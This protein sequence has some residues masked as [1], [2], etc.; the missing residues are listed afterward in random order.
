MSAAVSANENTVQRSQRKQPR[1]RKQCYRCGRNH[2]PEDCW[3]KSTECRRCMK[4]GHI[5]RMCRSEEPKAEN[6]KRGQYGK[7]NYQR[8]S[9][10]KESQATSNTVNKLD[11]QVQ[12]E[13]PKEHSD[14]D[15]GY[16]IIM[17]TLHE[18]GKVGDAGAIYLPIEIEGTVVNM[19]VDTGSG[20]SMVPLQFY[21]RHLKHIPLLPGDKSLYKSFTGQTVK[22]SGKVYVDVCYGNYEGKL[23]LYVMDCTEYYLLGREWLGVIPL[24]WKSPISQRPKPEKVLKVSELEQVI[25]K[26]AE[27]F[28]KVLGRKTDAEAKIVLR[29]EAQPVMRKPVKVPYV[30]K[31][32]VEAELD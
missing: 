20:I 12:R 21:E 1:S 4:I 29:E 14:S 5:E 16:D 27:L 13:N 3:F 25:N 9:G 10:K 26:H 18:E 28:E 6:K 24:D 11:E 19:E 17:L 8:K 32:K 15:S 22:P 7:K 2:L 23:K 31:E 30:L